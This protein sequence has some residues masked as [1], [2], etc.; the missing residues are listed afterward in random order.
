MHMKWFFFSLTRLIYR[1]LSS[2]SPLRWDQ[3]HVVVL[4][5]HSADIGYHGWKSDKL[6]FPFNRDVNLLLFITLKCSYAIVHHLIMKLFVSAQ[7]LYSAHRRIPR[8]VALL[9]FPTMYSAISDHDMYLYCISILRRFTCKQKV[10]QSILNTSKGHNMK[11]EI[12]LTL[13]FRI[14]ATS[15]ALHFSI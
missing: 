10:K 5:F 1:E 2:A 13:N 9:G 11:T 6:Q 3:W 8:S 12:L 4:L 14:R 15:T 7:H